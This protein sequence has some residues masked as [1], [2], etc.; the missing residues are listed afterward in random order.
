MPPLP[1]LETHLSLRHLTLIAAIDR[2]GSLLA[3]A[4]SVGLTQSAVTKAL[5]EAEAVVGARLFDRTNRG[6][7]PTQEGEVLI[8]HAKLVLTQLR[9][10]GQELEDMRSGSG[11]RVA[12]GVLVSAAV[13]LL[14]RAIADVRKARP[15]LAVK[16][17]EGTNDVLMPLLRAGEL[18][19]VIGRLPGFSGGAG[20]A[21]ETLCADHAQIVV[22][23]GHPLT[24][25]RGLTLADLL[26]EP[27]T[28]PRQET[29]MRRQIDEAFRVQGLPPPANSVESVS[30]LTNRSLVLLADYLVVWPVELARFEAA[31]GLVA[32]LDVPLP[33]TH[34]PIGLST[35]AGAR[36]SP[37]AETLIA[38]LRREAAG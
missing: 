1:R 31:Q 4:Q 9:H 17:I 36:L 32:A 5:Q 10:A 30:I 27:W 26:D 21:E 12:V 35:R 14:P 16:V 24:R 18:D 38:A 6:V 33:T 28:L 15:N 22:R 2:E 8:A 11:G 29:S 20:I 19:F 34:R 37:A 7:L 23:A 25:R 3:A 13:T